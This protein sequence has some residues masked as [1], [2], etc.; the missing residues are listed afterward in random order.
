MQRYFRVDRKNIAFLKFILEAYD[1]M[2]VMRTLGPHEG[3]V[4]LMIAP[5]FERDVNEI[6][7]N[8]RGEFEV[9]PIDP[10]ADIKEL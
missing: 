5:D 7:D 10:P 6:L 2:A 4:E 8:L 9:Q 1:G 3:V